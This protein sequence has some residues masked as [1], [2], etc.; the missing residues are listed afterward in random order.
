MGQDYV[1]D[2]REHKGTWENKFTQSS[3]TPATP[4]DNISPSIEGYEDTLP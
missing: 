4:A 3:P 1:Y 2:T